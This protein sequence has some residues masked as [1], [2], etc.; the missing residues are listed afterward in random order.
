[1]KKNECKGSTG[2]REQRKKAGKKGRCCKDC[3]KSSIFAHHKFGE[4]KTDY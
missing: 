4:P 3:E 1:V 2:K